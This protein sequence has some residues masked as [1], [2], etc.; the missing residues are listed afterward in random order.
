MATV[1]GAATCACGECG[2]GAGKTSTVLKTKKRTLTKRGV[3]WLG[4]TCNQRCYFCYFLNRIANAHHPEHPFMDIKKAKDMCRTLREFYGNTSI[5][6]QGGE[7]TIYPEILELIRYCKEIGLYPTLITNGIQLAKPGLLEQFRDAGVRD[8]LV[9]YHG[10]DELHDQVVGKTGA[11]AKMTEA[12]AHMQELGIPIRFNCTMSK[13]VVPLMPEIARKAIQYGAVAVNYIAFNPFE[14]QEAGVR[15]HENVAPYAEIKPKL[16]EAMD[17]LEEAGIEV[18]VRYLPICMAEPRHRKNFYNFQQLSYDHHE[19]DYQSWMWTGM[20]TQRMRDGGLMPPFL[21]G[22]YAR[23][24][25]QSDAKIRRDAYEQ[26]P[27]KGRLKYGVQH[28]L[29]RITQA[30]KGKDRVWREEAIVRPQVDLQ[31]RFHDGC[32]TCSARTICDGFHG[33]YADLFG[34]DEAKPITDV[35]PTQDPLYFIKDQDKV[36]EPEDKAWAL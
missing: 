36:V 16:T 30:M 12:V 8:F 26:S 22:P 1:E 4:Q 21:L 19:W 13:P 32:G 20:Q 31:Y 14:D 17:L 15:T 33:D 34:T 6:I 2:C 23:N 7:P 29:C 24:L 9:S 3:M 11:Y 27:L 5:D 18:N 28:L 10:I 35:A 25:Y